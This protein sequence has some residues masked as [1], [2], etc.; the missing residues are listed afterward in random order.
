[1]RNTFQ[2]ARGAEL[3]ENRRAL[4]RMRVV[5]WMFAGGLLCLGVYLGLFVGWRAFG[6]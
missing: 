2:R 4:R 5:V 6:W 3:E 1:M